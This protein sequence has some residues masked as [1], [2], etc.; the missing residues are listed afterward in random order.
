ME[1]SDLFILIL[2]DH[3][4]HV[5]GSILHLISQSCHRLL[6]ARNFAIN[7]VLLLEY[8]KILVS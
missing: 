6:K 7:L 2:D 4:M 5:L 1:S 8:G 3:R